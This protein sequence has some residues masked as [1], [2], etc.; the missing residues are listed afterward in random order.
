VNSVA[1][2]PDGAVIAS[3]SRDQ[4]VILWDAESGELLRTLEGH[5]DQVWT[6][7]F[8]PD[9][10][11]LASASD[12]ATVRLWRVAVGS[13]PRGASPYGMQ[14]M[15]GNVWEWVADWY[16]EDY[17]QRAPDR[18]P[19]G[20]S[21]GEYKVLRGGSWWLVACLARTADRLGFHPGNRTDYIGFRCAQ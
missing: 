8:S 2:S 15:A 7:A 13:Y 16:D 4:S 18:N 11:T 12:D 9:G 10:A 3:G 14:D 17:Y 19:M 1:F 21:S 6:V 5:T 20:A